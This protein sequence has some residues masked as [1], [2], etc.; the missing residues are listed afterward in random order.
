MLDLERHLRFL[1]LLALLACGEA[2]VESAGPTAGASADVATPTPA[3]LPVKAPRALADAVGKPV[4]VRARDLVLLADGIEVQVT[5]LIGTLKPAGD[6]VDLEVPTSFTLQIDALEIRIPE[7]FLSTWR[8]EGTENTPFKELAVRTE[9]N[10]FVL[11]G[12]ARFLNL[13]FTFRADPMVT[14]TGAL[15]LQLEKVRVLGIGLRGFLAAFERPVENAVNKQ[16]RFLD[17]EKDLL[18]IDPFPFMGPPRVKAAFTSVE[19]QKGAL[20]ARLGEAPEPDE[21]PQGLTLVGGVFRSGGSLLFDSTMS[22]IARDGGPLTIDPD[23]L[24]EQ[25]SA[26]FTKMVSAKRQLRFHLAPL[27]ELE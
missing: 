22:L 11:E 25:I 14:E 9:G 24:D 3:D 21:Y 2:P 7:Q 12:H 27:A 19:V 26:G 6:Y 16:Q 15:A 5:Y 20:V 10:S 18:V 4:A 23:R 8:P 17:V 13:P 1:P